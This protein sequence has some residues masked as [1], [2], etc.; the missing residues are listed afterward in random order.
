[1]LLSLGR[2]LAEGALRRRAVPECEI[3]RY[4]EEV[5]GVIRSAFR[6]IPLAVQFDEL[7]FDARTDKDRRTGRQIHRTE[8]C[9]HRPRK[10]LGRAVGRSPAIELHPA[11]DKADLAFI[12]IVRH[13]VDDLEH[14]G[15]AILALRHTAWI[16]TVTSDGRHGD[17]SEQASDDGLLHHSSPNACRRAIRAA[18]RAWRAFAFSISSSRSFW[19]PSSTLYFIC[20]KAGCM[21]GWGAWGRVPNS[22][23]CAS[24]L[25]EPAKTSTRS[26]GVLLR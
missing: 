8:G 2:T 7:E 6:Q 21:N 9:L 24:E 13:G 25:L 14:D 18:L 4:P 10:L 19:M 17:I 16:D 20:S 12:R 1:M 23:R 26:A 15:R 3:Q 11:F 5:F 22:G